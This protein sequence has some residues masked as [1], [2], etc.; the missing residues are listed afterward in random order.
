M[1][2]TFVCP[3]GDQ[4][5]DREY[6]SVCG[7]KMDGVP[8]AVAAD[9]GVE[10]CPSCGI[11]RKNG[12][13]FCETCRY[14]FKSPTANASATPAPMRATLTPV[15]NSPSAAFAEVAVVTGAPD[16]DV[17]AEPVAATTPPTPPVTVAPRYW[18]AIIEVDPALDV[19]P[20]PD[21]PC[22]T[23]TPQRTFPLDL[24]EN[25]VGRR[26]ASRGILPSIALSDPGVSH[27]HLMVYRN[28]DATLMVSDLGSTN[29]TFLNDSS[30]R[31]EAGVKTPVADG[32]HVELGRWTR[33]TFRRAS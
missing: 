11:E 10:R 5:D 29:G 2:V 19:E 32:D 1:A 3:K 22:P 15:T 31:L 27:R 13:R 20:D 6:C 8:T 28:P 14:D 25:L 4:S 18:E 17:A 23:D 33:M 26:S 12:A 24:A 16:P 30:D 21:T 9:P 7:I